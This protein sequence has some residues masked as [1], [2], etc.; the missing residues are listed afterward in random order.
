MSVMPDA[1]STEAGGGRPRALELFEGDRKMRVAALIS[2]LAFCI[3]TG[4]AS[5]ADSGPQPFVS[6]EDRF[7]LNFPTPPKVEEITYI[8][9]YKSPWK[10]HRYTSDVQGFRYI[11]TVVDMSTTVLTAEKDQFRNVGRPGN[12]RRGAMSFAANTL[13]KTGMVTLEG[14]E[15]L[16]VIP[17]YK[18]EITQAD[19]RQ[20]LVEI[21]THLKRLYILECISPPGEVPAYDIQSSLQLLDADGLVP[22]YRDNEYSFPDNMQVQSKLPLGQELVLPPGTTTGDA[23]PPAPAGAA[24]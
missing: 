4:A 17:G 14:Y 24:R 10:A 19:G 9:E 18:L 7:A 5:A 8:S 13:R 11:M 6:R 23:P 12:E 2:L 22:R 3:C 20:N 16:Q 21:H 15:E 1:N